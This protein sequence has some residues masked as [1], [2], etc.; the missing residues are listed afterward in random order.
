MK[1]A[2]SH[3]G[4]KKIIVVL[5]VLLCALIALCVL[6]IG[7]SREKDKT[8]EK[9]SSYLL[10]NSF[11]SIDYNITKYDAALDEI[12]GS[13]D[14]EKFRNLI[15]DFRYAVYYDIMN[16][17]EIIRYYPDDISECD[18]IYLD[19]FLNSVYSLC[20]QGELT[21]EVVSDVDYLFS[22]WKECDISLLRSDY[23]KGFENLS[24]TDDRYGIKAFASE[25]E[26]LYEKYTS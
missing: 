20:E 12:T 7:D 10:V 17:G 14:A 19:T 5:I 6:L 2:K 21:S 15:Y 11:D 24:F 3:D 23:N 13:S 4:R 9:A 1:T 22:C 8:A 16:I 18:L 25:V 26:R